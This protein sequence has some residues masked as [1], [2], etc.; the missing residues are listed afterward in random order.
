MS[1]EIT[2]NTLYSSAKHLRL[3]GL[4]STAVLLV[5]SAWFFYRDI[6]ALGYTFG[7]CTLMFLLMAVVG[8]SIMRSVRRNMPEK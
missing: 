6:P 5:G 1:E 3:G 8:H 4:I 7:V 2:L